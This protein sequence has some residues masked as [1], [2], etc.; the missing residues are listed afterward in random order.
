LVALAALLRCCAALYDDSEHVKALVSVGEFESSVMSADSTA[1]VL[2]VYSSE[3]CQACDGIEEDFAAGADE[4]FSAL[5]IKAAAV[6]VKDAGGLKIAKKLGV[7]ALPAVV[8]FGGPATI[9]PYTGK[10]HRDMA[11]F[12]FDSNAGLGKANFKRWAA[13]SAL[14]KDVV[15]RVVSLD[16]LK[17]ESPP[18]AFI[19]TERSATS[20][21]A[22]S[23]A[24]NMRGNLT[25]FELYAQ[26]AGQE[27]HP[28][29]AQ[30]GLSS[31]P[32]I[33]GVETTL[34]TAKIF[35]GALT[36]RA[37]VLEWLG[38][39]A[40]TRV[41]QA[42][43]EKAAAFE[44]LKVISSSRQFVDGVLKAELGTVVSL[45]GVDSV[46]AKKLDDARGVIQAVQLAPD[47][48][49]GEHDAELA[50]VCAAQ[51]E[52]RTA[53]YAHGPKRSLKK[54]T[55][56]ADAVQAFDAAAASISS[57]AVTV[58]GDGVNLDQLLSMALRPAGETSTDP[59]FGMIIFSNKDDVALSV[60]C[61]AIVL[62]KAGVEVL[63]YVVTGAAGDEVALQRFGVRK[64]PAVIGFHSAAVPPE[65]ANEG[66]FGIGVVPY[67]R[68]YFGPPAQSNLLRWTLTICD[69]IAPACS[70]E[71]RG[72]T[73]SASPETSKAAQKTA[74]KGAVQR[75]VMDEVATQA[76]WDALCGADSA[77]SLCAIVFLDEFGR[78]EN[79]KDELQIAT[80][81]ATSENA[82]ESPVFT[83]GWANG[84][85]QSE[86]A[87]AFGVV[88]TSLPT[89]VAYSP[90][91]GRSATFVGSFVEADLKAFLRGVLSGRVSTRELLQAPPKLETIDCKAKFADEEAAYAATAAADDDFDFMAEILAEETASKAALEREASAASATLKAEAAAALKDKA[92]A[93]AAAAAPKKKKKKKKAKADL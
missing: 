54:A 40:S 51:L 68:S 69:Q 34:E 44:A 87:L 71:I 9:N 11:S 6:D 3:N 82:A 33:V 42:P 72:L 59:R 15:Q 10:P 1:W 88:E 38:E 79:F 36:D 23:Y 76:Q 17:K 21:L 53:S 35:S 90:K 31:L 61:A 2:N 18:Y 55:F 86:L 22:K 7:N 49:A 65:G 26:K 43:E 62:Q 75:G 19:V 93:A 30:L 52:G 13:S 81:L 37:V 24:V 77:F 92:A 67:D 29:L 78:S 91:K 47:L 8:A 32:A 73:A 84:G 57:E 74:K 27:P 46:L 14:P 25:L 41:V 28:S 63:Q 64:V 66:S 60:R 50:A 12:Q 80:A 83:L 4:L 45:K 16:D 5:G 48:C 70:A 58:I 56:H 85:C 89:I 20:A 39:I